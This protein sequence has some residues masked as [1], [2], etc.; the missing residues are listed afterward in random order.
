[1]QSQFFCGSYSPVLIH[2]TPLLIVRMLREMTD[3]NQAEQHLLRWQ[4]FTMTIGL[5]C[6]LGPID[7]IP[8]SIDFSYFST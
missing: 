4:L 2:E 3:P 6:M 1:M 5:L 7:F 8:R